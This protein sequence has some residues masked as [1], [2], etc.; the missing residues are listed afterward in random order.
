MAKNVLLYYMLIKEVM[1]KK[2]NNAYSIQEQE[3]QSGR[4]IPDTVTYPFSKGS[5]AGNVRVARFFGSTWGEKFAFILGNPVPVS[6][7]YVRDGYKVEGEFNA[8]LQCDGTHEFLHA[9]YTAKIQ[10]KDDQT[11]LSMK[12]SKGM[13]KTPALHIISSLSVGSAIQPK[14]LED[15]VVKIK[16][17]EVSSKC[18][19]II[20]EIKKYIVELRKKNPDI[21]RIKVRLGGHGHRDGGNDFFIGQV[22]AKRILQTMIDEKFTDITISDASCMGRLKPHFENALTKR[23]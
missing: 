23:N 1:G 20:K 14:N 10:I 4:D 13:K 16:C 9:P 22:E 5:F 7:T 11:V 6:G 2:Y 12:R 8:K 17:D 3:S 21:K 18:D 15:R 19:R